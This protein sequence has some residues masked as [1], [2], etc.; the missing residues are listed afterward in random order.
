MAIDIADSFIKQFESEVHTA[1]QR[2]GSKL[3][4]TVR[5]KAGVVG[6]STTFQKVGTGTASTK[7][8][9]GQIAAMNVSH[10]PV[11]CTL[12]DYYAGD[13]VD[14]LDE[15]KTNIDERM[16]IAQA[17]AYAL[18]R[19]TDSLIITAMDTTTTA[20]ATTAG[21]LTKAK[22][23]EGFQKL[24]ENDVPDDGGRFCVVGAEQWND[25]LGVSEFISADY[26]GGESLPFTLGVTAKQWLGMT[27]FVHTGLTTS[28]SNRYVHMYHRGAI[29]FASGQDIKSDITWHGDRAAH[30][31][32]NMMSQ[33][34]CLID[35]N[36]VCK[37]T[38]A[39]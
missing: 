23:L 30:F 36:G 10:T 6:S 21:G 32:N 34:A 22:V 8:R 28:G 25:L 27:F 3:R 13:W 37:I 15:L 9:H 17:G 14:A 11:E 38:C 7:G 39:E 1:Y 19:K 2:T 18:G 31:I 35:T 5:T 33:G 29:G 16:V 12:Y 4:P 24:N 20:A 26:I